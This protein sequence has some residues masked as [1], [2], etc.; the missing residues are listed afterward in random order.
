MRRGWHSASAAAVAALLLPSAAFA[1]S[2]S[3]PVQ[4]GAVEQ[5]CKSLQG[6]TAGLP[7]Q[8]PGE[9]GAEPPATWPEA[10]AGLLP[11]K[12]FLRT[13]TESFNRLYEFATRDGR[14]YTRARDAGGGM[15]APARSVAITR[16]RVTGTS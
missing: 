15:R 6:G 1:Q 14:I 7:D 13:P 4:E 2:P 3:D 10:P 11:E 5:S 12:V 16:R 8:V 9:S